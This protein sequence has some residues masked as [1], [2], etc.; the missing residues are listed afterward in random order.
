MLPSPRLALSQTDL[1]AHAGCIRDSNRAMLLA[2][3]REVGAVGVDL[4]IV[5]DSYEA[6]KRAV[7]AALDSVDVLITS[8]GVRYAQS[9]LLWFSALAS[10]QAPC[11]VHHQCS[12]QGRERWGE[13]GGGWGGC[14]GDRALP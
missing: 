7:L 1:S 12:W 5:H 2:A 10:H 3:V 8:G 11:G 4:G 14:G 13:V 6:T 9:T